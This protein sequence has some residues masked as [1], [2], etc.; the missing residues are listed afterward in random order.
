M[1][2][3]YPF[4]THTGLAFWKCPQRQIFA[5]SKGAIEKLKRNSAGP[6]RKRPSSTLDDDEDDDDF[7]PT[8]KYKKNKDKLDE[9]ISHV[10]EIKE[11]LDNVMTLTEETPI[12]LPLKRILQDSFT[13]VVCHASPMKPPILISKC[14]KTILGCETCINGWYSGPDALTKTCP[15]CRATRGYNETM[16][17]KGLDDFLRQ[18]RAARTHQDTDDEL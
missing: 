6:S 13:C 2:T 3:A 10:S 15:T 1:I 18:V 17:L 5:V 11:S 4:I 7:E 9:L 14:C 12:P 8:V 16:Q